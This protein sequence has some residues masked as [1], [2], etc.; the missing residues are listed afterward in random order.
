MDKI[1]LLTRK[2]IPCNLCDATA[3]SLLSF[4]HIQEQYSTKSSELLQH[5]I[6]VTEQSI[7]FTVESPGD[8]DFQGSTCSW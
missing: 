5:K 8:P 2:Q 7:P 1:K 6:A 4:T 3:K